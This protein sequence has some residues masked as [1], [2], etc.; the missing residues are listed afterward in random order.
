MFVSH[1]INVTFLII[2]LARQ[3]LMAS[4]P[5]RFRGFITFLCETFNV[6]RTVN[7]EVCILSLYFLDMPIFST[8]VK[9]SI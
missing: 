2:I 1:L 7:N 3:E 9:N 4:D 8:N 5:G 6:M